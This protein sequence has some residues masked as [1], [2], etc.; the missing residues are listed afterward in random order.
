MCYV[1]LFYEVEF[2][3]IFHQSDKILHIFMNRS[4]VYTLYTV[5]FV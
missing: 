1:F 4:Y 2:F 5:T 3:H